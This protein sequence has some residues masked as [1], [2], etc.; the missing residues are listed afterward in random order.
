MS[1]KSAS[2][3]CISSAKIRMSLSRCTKVSSAVIS[4][5]LLLS[6]L[7]SRHNTS[8]SSFNPKPVTDEMNTTGR[9]SGSVSRSISMSS[10]SKRSLFVTASTRCLSSISGLNCCNSLSSTS[11]SCL[12]S[13]VS[14]GT[15]NSKS[16]LRSM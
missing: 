2:S 3:A 1:S 5:N 16:E 14:P 13:S 15:I 8:F 9:S 7:S 11:Y 10:S 12:M 4:C 6:L